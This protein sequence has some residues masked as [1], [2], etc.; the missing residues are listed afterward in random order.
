MHPCTCRSFHPCPHFLSPSLLSLCLVPLSLKTIRFTGLVHWHPAWRSSACQPSVPNMTPSKRTLR[1][2]FYI[3]KMNCFPLQSFT[4][5]LQN[6]CQK[7]ARRPQWQWHTEPCSPV[8]VTTWSDGRAAGSCQKQRTIGPLWYK[9]E[10]RLRAIIRFAWRRELTGLLVRAGSGT[11][12]KTQEAT[13]SL[14]TRMHLWQ[15]CFLFFFINSPS[16]RS[17]CLPRAIWVVSHPCALGWRVT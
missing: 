17:M 6:I 4:P 11:T 12:S 14:K 2:R 8:K 5:S 1:L 9:R 16:N 10:T 7:P 13:T 15:S 3:E